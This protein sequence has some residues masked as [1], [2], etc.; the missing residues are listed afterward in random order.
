MRTYKVKMNCVISIKMDD[1]VEP[2]DFE[3]IMYEM[4]K[5]DLEERDWKVEELN[6]EGWGR[7]EKTYQPGGKDGKIEPR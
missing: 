5:N 4:I 1:S 3:E 7:M 6:I 2:Y